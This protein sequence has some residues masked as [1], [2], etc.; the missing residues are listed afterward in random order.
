MCRSDL[1]RDTYNT[2]IPR[3]T[4]VTLSPNKSVCKSAYSFRVSYGATGTTL[5]PMDS[6]VYLTLSL[7]LYSLFHFP[8]LAC[9]DGFNLRHIHRRTFCLQRIKKKRRESPSYRFLSEIPSPLHRGR[10]KPSPEA[11]RPSASIGQWLLGFLWR[12]SVLAGAGGDLDVDL[13]IGDFPFSRACIGGG[14][15]SYCQALPFSPPLIS[16]LS[17]V[18]TTWAQIAA[19]W[20]WHEYRRHSQIGRAPGS[21]PL[22]RLLPIRPPREVRGLRK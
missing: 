14:G 3:G 13:A 17:L 4:V 5:R 11:P 21:S 22:L 9:G 7:S 20:E 1:G 15:G 8:S 12:Q 16:P 6:S 10:R 19:R 2:W 18:P